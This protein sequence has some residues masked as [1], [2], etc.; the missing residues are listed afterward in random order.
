MTDQNHS[1]TYD[2]TME[3]D[4][5]NER[6][7]P[8]EQVREDMKKP[9]PNGVTF[10]DFER[11]EK[12]KV[13]GEEFTPAEEALYKEGLRDIKPGIDTLMQLMNSQA[14]V[15][16]TLSAGARA[17]LEKQSR[18]YLKA[19]ELSHNSEGIEPVRADP[20]LVDAV[21]TLNAAMREQIDKTQEQIN[22]INDLKN[23]TQKAGRFNTWTA[24]VIMILTGL[25]VAVGVVAVVVAVNGR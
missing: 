9:L 1:R 25:G 22:G 4:S 5:E 11:L 21:N 15:R 2:W 18:M 7:V 6:R 10:D 14:S 16:D 19:L 20:V 23:E 3:K 12:K 8:L 13:A 17:N 24:W